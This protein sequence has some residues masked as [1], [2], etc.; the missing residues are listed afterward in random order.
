MCFKYVNYKSAN[1]SVGSQLLSCYCYSFLILYAR[2][3]LDAENAE[4]G[5]TITKNYFLYLFI[6]FG[7]FLLFLAG[8]IKIPLQLLSVSSFRLDLSSWP[9]SVPID[10]I[11]LLVVVSTHFLCVCVHTLSLFIHC[12]FFG[13]SRMFAYLIFGHIF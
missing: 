3:A 2:C 9:L 7:F 5:K 1:F 13:F 6:Y 4:S 10:V 12:F 8:C 11:M